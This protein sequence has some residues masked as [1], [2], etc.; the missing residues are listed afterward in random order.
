MAKQATQYQFWFVTHGP[1]GGASQPQTI[2]QAELR[3][4]LRFLRA[5]G[6]RI[7]RR[8]DG[9]IEVPGMSQNAVAI[10]RPMREAA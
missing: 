2:S 9:V 5:D 8:P 1:R 4:T 10:I 6:K 3:S 7:C